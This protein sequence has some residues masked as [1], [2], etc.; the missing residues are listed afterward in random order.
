MK[1]I[2]SGLKKPLNAKLL[3][4]MKMTIIFLLFFVFQASAD[5]FGQKKFTFSFKNA[6]LSQV[7][8]AIEK[9][10]DYRFL[11]NTN[12]EGLKQKISFSVDDANLKELL[13]AI[14][15]NTGLEYEL[16]ENNLIVIKGEELSDA[17]AIVTGKVTGDNGIILSGVSVQIKGSSKG[18]FNG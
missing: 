14:F 17:K 10:S 1:F 7:L 11:Y 9:K 18:T 13:D 3:L 2:S 6:E 16:M 15:Q 5:G 12:L 4:S 8:S